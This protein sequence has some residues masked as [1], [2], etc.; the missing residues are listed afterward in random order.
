MNGGTPRSASENRQ[1]HNFLWK[2]EES[3]LDHRSSL[4]DQRRSLLP[5]PDPRGAVSPR[6]DAMRIE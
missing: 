6:V 4:T 5:E 1:Q 2:A 3:G